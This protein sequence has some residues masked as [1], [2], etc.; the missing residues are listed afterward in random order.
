MKNLNQSSV[1]SQMSAQDSIISFK[2]N[3]RNYYFLLT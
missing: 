1:K 3:I 2:D